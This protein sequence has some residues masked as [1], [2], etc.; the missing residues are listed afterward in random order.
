MAALVSH[1]PGGLGVFEVVIPAMLPG[2]IPA[3]ETLGAL[4]VFRLI[5]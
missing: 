2:E 3:T 4:L 1:I 5:Y